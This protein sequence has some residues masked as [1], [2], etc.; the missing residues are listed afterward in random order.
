MAAGKVMILDAGPRSV[1]AFVPKI[2]QKA[3]ERFGFPQAALLTDWPAI[4]GPELARFTEPERLKWPRRSEEPED[5]EAD[6]DERKSYGKRDFSGAT[7]VLRVDGP[8][9]IEV[10][11]KAPQIL[12]RINA[13]FGFRAVTEL[14][15]LQAPVTR[16]AAGRPAAAPP[17]SEAEASTAGSALDRA[18]DRLQR[19]VATR[20]ASG[21]V[22]AK[23]SKQP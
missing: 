7:L 15:I 23:P 8:L 16:K 9:A 3:F 20:C 10:Q 17:T 2:T 18:L 22:A 19:N 1:G 13:Y 6:P 4:I 11:H 5:G 14:R 12:E 21:A